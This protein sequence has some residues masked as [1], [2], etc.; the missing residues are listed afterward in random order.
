MRIGRALFIIP[1]IVAFGV[2]GL[3]PAV[4]DISAAAAS[5]H[6]VHLQAHVSPQIK[7][8]YHHD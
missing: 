1:A 2:A 4:A 7:G 6:S 5:V 3:A 8:T